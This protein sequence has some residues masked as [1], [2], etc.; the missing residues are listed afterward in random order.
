MEVKSKNTS[1]LEDVNKLYLGS[2]NILSGVDDDGDLLIST[3]L[4]LSNPVRIMVSSDEFGFSIRTRYG[5]GS[6]IGKSNLIETVNDINKNLREGSFIVDG[7]GELI[8]KNF[9]PH[10]DGISA[11]DIASSIKISVSTFLTHVD[12]VMEALEPFIG[13]EGTSEFE[14]IDAEVN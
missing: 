4:S 3:Y 12:D 6:N 10:V 1:I 13:T 9:I 5:V 8:F 2:L 11:E 7:D 14:I